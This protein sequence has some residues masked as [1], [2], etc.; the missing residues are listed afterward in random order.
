MAAGFRTTHRGSTANG[1][2]VITGRSIVYG[3]TL[4]VGSRAVTG[5]DIVRHTAVGNDTNAS[6]R[7]VTGGCT[8]GL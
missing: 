2:H 7:T 3:L 8:A 5:G 6:L 1:Y 4:I